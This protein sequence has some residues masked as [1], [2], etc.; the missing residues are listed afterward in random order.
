MEK[1]PAATLGEGCRFVERAAGASVSESTLSGLLRRVGLSPK[2]GRCW[3]RANATSLEGRSAGARGRQGRAG[4][5]V[6][7]DG[8]S[9]STSLSPLYGWALTV[10]LIILDPVAG[11]RHEQTTPR[12]LQG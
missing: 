10:A 1:R 2:G 3:V 12:R 6:F 9:T 5:S 8:C 7:V 11:N 4:R